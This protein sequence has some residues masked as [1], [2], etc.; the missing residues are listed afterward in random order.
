MQPKLISIIINNYNYARFL[1][2]A[3]DSALQQSYEHVEVLVVDDGSTDH[4][5]DVMRSYGQRIIAI[6]KENGGQASAFNAGLAKCHGEIVIFLDA[7]DLL[8]PR[9]AQRVADA[10]GEH[11]TTSKLQYRM[12][13]IDAAGRRTGQI[14]PSRHLPLPSGDLRCQVLS[15]PFDLTWMAT[16]G[17]AFAVETLRRI[18]P[19]PEADYPI[20]ADYYLAHLT[21]LL[22]N[23][24]FLD[25]IG[26]CYRVH[27]AN[28]HEASSPTLNLAHIR[29]S[30]VYAECTNRHI[31]RFAKQLGL[32]HL[33]PKEGT[34]SV[35]HI[36]Q[37]MVSHKFDPA[38]H[39]VA[40]DNALN[41]LWSGIQAANRR[42][43]VTLPMRLSFMAW[44]LAMSLAPLSGARWLAERFFFPESRPQI[45]K[46]LQR[47]Q[48]V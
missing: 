34:L 9:T 42:F 35:S 48:A 40:A 24:L 26:A 22:G 21:P 15:F 31:Q 3:I 36:A 16:S 13:I 39:P 27:G 47:W 32:D 8:L 38:Q 12:A 5:P 18:F 43:D 30:I 11:P 4:S 33:A 46:L 17:N 7:D 14:K 23:V 29:K 28:H 2:A 19:M 20:L 44:F 1:P 45:N 41:L 37:R 6:Y 25:E 10:F